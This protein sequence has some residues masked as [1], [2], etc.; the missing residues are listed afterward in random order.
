MEYIT[1]HT[2]MAGLNFKHLIATL[3][4]ASILLMPTSVLAET[5]Y[6]FSDEAQ[7]RFEQIEQRQ[8]K[9]IKTEPQ[10]QKAKKS[11]QQT[12]LEELDNQ[13]IAPAKVIQGNLTYIEEGTSF[14]VVLQS[15]IS[16]G[17]L[18]RNDTI[19]ASLEED[20]TYQNQLIAPKGSVVY[21]RAL[22]SNKAGFFYANGNMTITFDTIMLPTGEQLPLTANIVTI[23]TNGNRV[24]KS[25]IQ[26]LT[27]ALAGVATGVLY[28]LISGGNVTRGLA[29]GAGVGATGGLVRA[30]MSR[31]EESEIPAGTRI[32]VRLTKPMNANPYKN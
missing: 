7:A 5:F 16:S 1:Y 27:G 22:D 3:I 29:V 9:E 12:K 24:V 6:D 25:G 20:W 30:G 19:A 14:D 23:K 4:C 10:V 17:S 8:P 28:A 11:R 21:G 13:I 15:S 31:G 18:A 26:V 2:N 32:N